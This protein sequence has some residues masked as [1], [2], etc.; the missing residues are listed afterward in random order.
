M[1]KLPVMVEGMSDASETNDATKPKDVTE[2]NDA[3][4]AR[5]KTVEV[6]EVVVVAR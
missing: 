5:I 1:A 4:E 6:A 2:T 3:T